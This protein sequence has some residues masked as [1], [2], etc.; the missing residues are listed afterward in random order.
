MHA[1]CSCVCMQLQ[2]MRV[3][4]VQCNVNP[5]STCEGLQ[6]TLASACKYTACI[7][8]CTYCSLVVLLVHHVPPLISLYTPG[9]KNEAINCPICQNNSNFWGKVRRKGKLSYTA[10]HYSNKKYMKYC[11]ANLS[12]EI[13]ER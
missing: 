11:F 2:Y 6:L 12:V 7:F 4:S 3:H 1:S 8:G 13:K 5:V 10:S 9:Q